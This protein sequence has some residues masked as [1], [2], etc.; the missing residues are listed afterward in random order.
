MKWCVIH[1]SVAVGKQCVKQIARNM[2]TTLTAICQLSDISA[3][4]SVSK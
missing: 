1:Y 4:Y 2:K 3:W